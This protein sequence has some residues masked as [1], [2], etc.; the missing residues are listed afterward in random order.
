MKNYEVKVAGIQ[1]KKLYGS[2]RFLRGEPI[3]LD[4]DD[5]LTRAFL[6]GRMIE[7]IKEKKAETQEVKKTVKRKKGNATA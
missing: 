6:K 4:P 5:P 3:K 7:E 2:K 1:Q